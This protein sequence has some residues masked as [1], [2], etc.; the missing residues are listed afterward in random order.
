MPYQPA[1]F[2]LFEKLYPK[3]LRLIRK[4]VIV[5]RGSSHNG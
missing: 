4:A 3:A 5:G 2:A 1:I